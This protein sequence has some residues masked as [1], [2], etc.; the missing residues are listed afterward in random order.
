MD[1]GGNGYGD[2]EGAGLVSWVG[3][4]WG[5]MVLILRV[6]SIGVDVWRG[7]GW[8]VSG[9]GLVKDGE[10]PLPSSTWLHNC[11]SSVARFRGWYTDRSVS[12]FLLRTCCGGSIYP[13]I[14]MQ[15][16]KRILCKMQRHPLDFG[17]SRDL[18]GSMVTL[19]RARDI[20]STAGCR[21]S[22][23]VHDGE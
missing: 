22:P 21:S 1:R 12:V 23:L 11:A 3:G 14:G 19:P 13:L 8:G 16:A 10:E 6:L 4:F 20:H 7:G 9:T 5:A 15:D 17:I 2:W 18:G